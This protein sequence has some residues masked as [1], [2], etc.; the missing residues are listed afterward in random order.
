MKESIIERNKR[1]GIDEKV[2]SFMVK[3]KFAYEI[4]VEYAAKR[5]REFMLE[6]EKRGLN[7]HVSVGGL[8]SITLLMFLRKIGI[9]APAISVSSLEDKSIQ[10][11]HKELGVIPVKPLKSKVQV[12]REYGYPILS[13]EIAGKIDLL[14]NPSE[15][16]KTVRHAIITGETGEYGGN[17][18]GT[19]MQLAHRWQRRH[20]FREAGFQGERQMLLLAERKTL[21]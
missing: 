3:Q 10:K 11:I 18:T 20:A 12:I 14:Q 9:D 16:N 15:K 8:D 21:R 4:K 5:A 2:A 1:I 7:Y 17:R 13:K 19:R 6:C